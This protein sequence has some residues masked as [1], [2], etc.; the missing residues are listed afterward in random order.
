MGL[1]RGSCPVKG[2]RGLKGN[3]ERHERGL[4]SEFSLAPGWRTGPRAGRD[5][6]GES[7]TELWWKAEAETR[8]QVLAEERGGEES[9]VWREDSGIADEEMVCQLGQVLHPSRCCFT[10]GDSTRKREHCKMCGFHWHRPSPCQE[11]AG[12]ESGQ[13]WPCLPGVH[14]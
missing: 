13:M 11:P 14:I 7:S 4:V 12:P 8:T 2:C 1:W 10:S 5:G 6:R 3:Q 9:P